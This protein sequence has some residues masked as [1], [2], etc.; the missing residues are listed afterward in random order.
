MFHG[1][2][3]LIKLLKF[4]QWESMGVYD[5]SIVKDRRLFDLIFV[6]VVKNVEIHVIVAFSIVV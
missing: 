5:F 3:L 1:W 4:L 6:F 2:E